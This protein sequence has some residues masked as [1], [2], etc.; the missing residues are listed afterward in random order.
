MADLMYDI[1]S[2]W[3]GPVAPREGTISWRECT[4]CALCLCCATLVPS[5]CV[6]GWS[7]PGVMHPEKSTFERTTPRH[8]DLFLPSLDV[9]FFWLWSPERSKRGLA[10]DTV[11]DGSGHRLLRGMSDNL[12]GQRAH[13]KRPRKPSSTEKEVELQCTVGTTHRQLDFSSL[14]PLEKYF[15]GNARYMESFSHASAQ[16]SHQ[17]GHGSIPRHDPVKGG[18]KQAHIIHSCSPKMG[19]WSSPKSSQSSVIALK[20][21]QCLVHCVPNIEQ[22]FFK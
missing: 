15:L 13:G 12:P 16:S 11:M 2:T 7:S 8:V 9:S 22:P 4:L 10:A 18:D 5:Q 21:Y 14:R 19:L 3:Q 20:H 6:W 17:Q 1:S